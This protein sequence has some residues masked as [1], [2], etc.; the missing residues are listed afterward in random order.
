MPRSAIDQGLIMAGSFATGYVAGSTAARVVGVI[1]VLGGA[2]TL[3]IAGVLATGARSAQFLRTR[4]GE[5]AAATDATSVWA[6]TGVEVLVAVGVAG[7]VSGG[8]RP[9]VGALGGIAVAASAASDVQTALAPRDDHVDTK[10]VATATG[11]ATGAMAAV[12]GLL[13]SIRL[14][15]RLAKGATGRTGS[16]GALVHSAVSLGVAGALGFAAKAALNHVIRSIAAGNR[17]VEIAYSNPPEI[18]EVS[19]GAHS[20]IPY[21]SLGLQGRRL[22]SVATPASTIEDVMGESACK[23]PVRVFV[24]ADSGSSIEDRVEL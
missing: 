24:G 4:R 22:V 8:D 1:P 18:P 15:G 7:A 2:S 23:N 3:R 9:A 12:A 13:T 20:L 14:S 21:D 19:G 17:G 16:A 6:E 11:V 10:Y 5:S